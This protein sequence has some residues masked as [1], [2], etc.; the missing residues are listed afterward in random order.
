MAV[1]TTAPPVDAMQISR[2]VRSPGVT[3]SV[4]FR[5]APQ[6]TRLLNVSTKNSR[7]GAHDVLGKARDVTSTAQKINKV[8][9]ATVVNRTACETARSHSTKPSRL[10]NSDS[11][12]TVGANG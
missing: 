5:E 12:V 6:V 2:N 8:D 7:G 10:E 1:T 3:S 4:S 9:Y 11:Y